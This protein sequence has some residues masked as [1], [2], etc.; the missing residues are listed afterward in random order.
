MTSSPLI[1][2]AA[3]T[4]GVAGCNRSAP[5]NAQLPAALERTPPSSL[6][7]IPERGGRP[8][9]YL[10]PDL[11]EAE[12]TAEDRVPAV[13]QVVGSIADPPQALLVDTRGS[14]LSFGLL[15]GRIRTIIGNVERA[16]LAA[17]GSLFVVD[18]AG[19]A[20][21]VGRRTPER[22]QH[23]FAGAPDA[24]YTGAEGLL[25][26]VDTAAPAVELL[27]SRDT[28]SVR[29][30]AS[31]DVVLT[32]WGDAAAAVTATSILTYD[33][34]GRGAPRTLDVDDARAVAFSP[35][36]HQLYV[37]TADGMFT[38]FDRYGLAKLHSIKLPGAAAALRVGPYGR[39]LLARSASD[40]AV[41]VIDLDRDAL[42]GT[43]R[44]PWSERMPMITSPNLLLALEDSALVGRDL[45]SAAL[46]E[47]GRITGIEASYFIPVAWSPVRADRARE[48]LA[49]DSLEAADSNSTGEMTYLQVSSSQNPAWARELAGKLVS[50]GLRASVLDPPGDG[51]PYRVVLGPFRSREEADESGRTLG[52][53]NFVI[54]ASR[55]AAP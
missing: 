3:L 17:D 41:W 34:A 32:N 39:W 53:P 49:A 19:R 55:R 36:G 50:A 11:S 16:A 15:S 52:M 18:S 51:E 45:T 28:L 47:T 7:R 20:F 29:P 43:V 48:A 6:V 27:S 1:L 42:V 2:V 14:L 12:W 40:D 37:A 21:S 13:A 8:T 24:L 26:A 38:I 9:L 33:L 4:I 54:T 35:S 30:I 44:T 25:I 10:L 23:E 5:P 22:Y 31:G 46:T